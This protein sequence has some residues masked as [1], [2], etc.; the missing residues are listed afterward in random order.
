MVDYV[1]NVPQ[2]SDPNWL[3]WSKP[4]ERPVPDRSG[5]FIG[6][7]V[8]EGIQG[9]AQLGGQAVKSYAESGAEDILAQ[10]TQNLE[11]AQS[12]LKDQ[13]PNKAPQD[14]MKAK[15][16]A[17]TL[18]SSKANGAI[19]ETYYLGQLLK[20]QKDLRSQ[21]PMFRNQID[22]GIRQATGVAHT[23]NEYYQNVLKD[24]NSFLT[25]KDEYLKATQGETRQHMGSIDE[26][27]ITSSEALRKSRNGEWTADQLADYNDRVQ[28]ADWKN[29]Q[30]ISGLNA[31]KAILGD[32]K[33][34]AIPT[35][36]NMTHNVVT[37]V[38]M[39]VAQKM[40][41]KSASDIF[42]HMA[43]PASPQEA[44]KLA[45]AYSTI[46]PKIDQKIDERLNDPVR[47][48]SGNI[49]IDPRTG[50]PMSTL[51]Q[52]IGPEEVQKIKKTAK[53]QWEAGM[54]FIKDGATGPLAHF[55]NVLKAGETAFH[56]DMARS[57]AGNVMMMMK[58]LKEQGA[59]EFLQDY[60]RDKLKSN[61][62]PQLN[63]LI[64]PLLA[65]S[66]FGS[67]AELDQASPG[68]KLTSLAKD[69]E[70]VTKEFGKSPAAVKQ[71]VDDVPRIMNDPTIP[72][73][74]K[75]AKIKYAMG[76]MEDMVDRSLFMRAWNK[77]GRPVALKTMFGGDTINE[78]HRLDQKYH[79]LNLFNQM[80]STASIHVRDMIGTEVRDLAQTQQM[81][82][83]GTAP[84]RLKYTSDEK[85]GVHRFDV[86]PRE[87]TKI[88]GGSF[89]GTTQSVESAKR[90]VERINTGISVLSDIAR[91]DKSDPDAYIM[92]SLK[93]FGYT[94]DGTTFP[95]K[96]MSAVKNT[97]GDDLSQHKRGIEM[98]KEKMTPKK[99]PE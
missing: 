80:K 39:A 10:Q 20:Y 13:D 27:G 75:V 77:D 11:I 74:I 59:P 56:T 7:A 65:K 52:L 25:N 97:F 61:F 38:Q 63:G 78:V 26:N 93:S 34:E 71:I 86:V 83:E 98:L 48:K 49:V 91:V 21:F 72:D 60:V 96:M 44:Q 57:E 70:T 69:V 76:N 14:V 79:G 41:L 54:S 22:E 3:G 85:T 36:Q 16:V 66:Y 31:K 45:E 37:E 6:K 35:A 81:F 9:A 82:T 8:G 4:V 89:T 5:E 32:I 84:Y 67:Q 62:L 47:D 23:A 19:S 73:S 92:E 42:D 87:D 33:E 88:P 1:P 43:N 95:D 64:E 17:E 30:I 58:Y 51:A 29:K 99:K 12:L 46:G 24:L 68:A 18:G 55:A 15:S 2:T 40:G 28:A 90:A 94:P 53:E 50:K